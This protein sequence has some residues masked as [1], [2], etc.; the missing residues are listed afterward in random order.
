M[1]PV[2]YP[3]GETE[4]RNNG[5]GR[6]SDAVKCLVTEERN[7]QYELEMQYPVTG[8]HYKE[9]IEE[10]IIAAR[11][12]DSEDIQPFRIYKITRPMNGVIT[13]NARH[14]SYQLSKVAVMPFTADNCP[15]ALAGLVENSVGDCPFTIWTDRL[16]EANFS[17]GQ[18][19][20]FRSLLG[21]VSG[22]I[23]DV[24]GPGEY[25]W[26]KFTVKFHSRRGSDQNVYI[27]YGK[28][29]TDVKKTSDMSNVWTGILPFWAGTDEAEQAVLVTLPEKAI[30][31][32]YADDYIYKMVVPVDMSSEFESK[33]TEEQLR[34]RAQSYVRGNAADGIPAT[35]DVS[36]VAL[37]QTEEYMN[38]AP[39]QKL[40]LC[41]TVTVYHKGLGIE[42][43]A[44]I[45]SVTYDVLLEKYEKMTIGEVKS[46]LGDS[47]RQISEE[48]KKDVPT[49][50]SVSQA[51]NLAM[52]ILSGSL[53]GNIVINTNERGQPVE[54]LSMD[55]ADINTARKVLKIN[56]DGISI[57]TTGYSGAFTLVVDMNGRFPEL[58][59]AAYTDSS[60]YAASGH[61]HSGSDITSG[62]VNAA[63]LPV[64]SQGKA[65]IA[66]APTAAQSSAYLRGDGA[67][68]NPAATT[69]PGKVAQESTVGTSSN[70]AR[71]DHTHGLDL[72][73]GDADGQVKIAGVNVAVKGL[74]SAAFTDSEEYASAS[75]THP[76]TDTIPS[77][78]CS[79]DSGTSLKEASCTGYDLLADSYLQVVM[80]TSNTA[81]AALTMN[82][83]GR[84]A[85]PIFI[86]GEISSVANNVLPAGSYFVYYDGSG[87]HFRTD[88]KI[89]GI[90]DLA[91]KEAG[92]D[93]E[94]IYLPT[95][96][97][98]GVPGGYTAYTVSNGIIYEKEAPAEEGGE[99]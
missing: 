81:V 79:T 76:Q 17:V 68:N 7:G 46:H 32:D 93:I 98:D 66:P 96:L 21:G 35:I 28:N 88:G 60:S 62:T 40:K 84:G 54:I 33:P 77:A 42:N 27:R 69:A 4:F 20:S 67:W 37:W 2:L 53:G 1:K 83:N 23:L 39:L 50:A 99:E 55:T 43:K 90:G 31:S 75:H 63:R 73:E 38:W 22:S 61:K 89:P 44:K 36:F 45:V 59:G 51:I 5:F 9:I 19:A 87:Y 14:I 71:Q 52:N 94:T 82:V 97:E 11:H 65:G 26:D 85:K 41:D 16:V 6:L 56:K 47:I 72:A 8:I 13:I 30:Y 49:N 57:S 70:F 12:D 58:G 3:A 78:Y 80:A 95:T 10:R 92:A 15:E 91:Y 18:P 64:V 86:N 34:V 25:E 48:I 74:G 24:Y 29:M